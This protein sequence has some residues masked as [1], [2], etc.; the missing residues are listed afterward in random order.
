MLKLLLGRAGAG[1]TEAVLAAM[2]ARAGE[3]PQV[4]LVPEQHSHDMERAPC[5]AGGSAVSLGA[6]VLSF[7]RLAGRVFARYG[8]LAAP[9]LDGG[10]RVLL[11]CRALRS[12]AGGL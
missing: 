10:G 6:E 5:R 9:A 4:L 3:R 7:T 2:A 12:G 1:K 11:V 8:G